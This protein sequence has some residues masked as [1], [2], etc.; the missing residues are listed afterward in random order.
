MPV[1]Q[2][3]SEG[4]AE[5]Q[6]PRCKTTYQGE[7]IVEAFELLVGQYIDPHG[8]RRNVCLPCRTTAKNERKA[9]NR[10]RIKAFTT[11]RNHAKRLELP[12]KALEQSYGWKI[13]RM[14]DDALHALNH[15][16]LDCDSPIIAGSGLQDLNLDIINPQDPPDYGTNVRWICH[17][18]NLE[19]SKT[20][21]ARWN[22]RRRVWKRWRENRD[23]H[24]PKGSLFDN[25][26]A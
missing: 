21:A 3:T 5:R 1:L 19:K 11:R 4:L 6:C 16:C 25:D 24:W 7:E 15:P 13:S 8:K 22:V 23:R 2:R 26:A 18:C 20:P 12:V 9:K 14:V 10:L 17:T